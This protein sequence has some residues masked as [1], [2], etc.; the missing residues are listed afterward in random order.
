MQHWYEKHFLS[1][2][3]SWAEKNAVEAKLVF[4]YKFLFYTVKAITVCIVS[5][6]IELWHIW[7]IGVCADPLG[8]GLDLHR[9]GEAGVIQRHCSVSPIQGLQCQQGTVLYCTVPVR[10]RQ[11]PMYS[12]AWN[13]QGQASKVLCTTLPSFSIK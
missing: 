4:F 6:R 10:N 9:V 7:R 2:N 3:F 1:S 8:Q 11:V 13:Q 5:C 12:A